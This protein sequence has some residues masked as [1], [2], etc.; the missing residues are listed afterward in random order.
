[1]IGYRELV[2]LRR[3]SAALARGGIRYLHVADD[4]VAYVREAKGETVLCLAA[5]AAARRAFASQL[6]ALGGSELEP[7]HGG[8]ASVV[9]GEALLP[10][11]GPAFHAWRVA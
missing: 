10:G 11:D 7:L 6:A 4:A 8:D 5:R 1:M 9:S 2:S 3:S